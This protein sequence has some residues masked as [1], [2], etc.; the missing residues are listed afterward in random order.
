MSTD[1]VAVDAN[2]LVY[3]V[4]RDTPQHAASRAWLERAVRGEV[5]ICLTSQVLAEFFAIVTNPKRVSDPRTPD[6][7]VTAIEAT[8]ALPGATLLPVA[9][10]VT[11]RWLEMLRH[12]PVRGGAVFDLQLIATLAA[13]G[14]DRICTFNRA[15]FERF[16]GLEI[17]TP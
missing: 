16:P 8:L 3:A 7:A 4:Y 2:I 17:V 12:H 15:D 11:S 1:R 14:V 13:N 10:Q 5:K 9:P 6:D